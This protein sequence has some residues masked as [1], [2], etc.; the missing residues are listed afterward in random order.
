[1][2]CTPQAPAITR[3]S[4]G[5][6]ASTTGQYTNHDFIRKFVW[7]LTGWTLTYET[8]ITVSS[9][10]AVQF[11][12]SPI[13]GYDH[14]VDY[15]NHNSWFSWLQNS[16]PGYAE[17][18]LLSYQVQGSAGVSSCQ[19]VCSPSVEDLAY[20]DW[21]ND[22]DQTD[23]WYWDSD[24]CRC[25]G[26]ASPILIDLNN[27]GLALTSAN[28]GVTFDLFANS[29]PVRVAWTA[30]ASID[31][32]FLVLDRNGNGIIDNGA[33]EPCGD[34][35]RHARKGPVA[36]PG[37]RCVSCLQIGRTVKAV[38]DGSKNEGGR[39]HYDPARP[40]SARACRSGPGT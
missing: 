31:D 12:G 33:E 6:D 15:E 22:R 27:D 10:A 13:W 17:S 18:E 25:N 5:F 32:A 11:N 3:W 28:G 16:V 39:N 29:M 26:G 30:T 19:Q 40:R 20:C 2:Y 14:Y 4:N 21:L 37:G 23:V 8:T 35:P 9:T 7:W 1:M 36:A 38:S 34:G 24:G